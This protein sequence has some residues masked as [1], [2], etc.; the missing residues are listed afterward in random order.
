MNVNVKFSNFQNW[1]E[2]ICIAESL[3]FR[4]R[5]FST[6]RVSRAPSPVKFVEETSDR[7]EQTTNNVSNYE[8]GRIKLPSTSSSSEK[9]KKVQ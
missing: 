6:A 7:R 5:Q 4:Q 9:K 3:K 8:D 1:E 2:I